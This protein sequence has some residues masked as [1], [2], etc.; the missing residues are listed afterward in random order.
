MYFKIVKYL[1]KITQLIFVV[2]SVVLIF[3]ILHSSISEPSRIQM[4]YDISTNSMLL[5]ILILMYVCI[6]YKGEK[7]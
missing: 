5:I 1:K 7:D 2:G 4:I 3:G 6:F